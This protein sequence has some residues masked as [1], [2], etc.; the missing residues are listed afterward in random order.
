MAFAD[1]MTTNAPNTEESVSALD[2]WHQTLIG[3]A[4]S[5][6]EKA[7]DANLESI[8]STDLTVF[9]HQ[10]LDLWH[11]LYSEDKN[12]HK[13]YPHFGHMTKLQKRRAAKTLLR[14]FASNNSISSI[15]NN[16]RVSNLF[17]FERRCATSRLRSDS[18]TVEVEGLQRHKNRYEP[19]LAAGYVIISIHTIFFINLVDV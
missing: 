7:H 19:S 3:M 11:Q 9:F 13:K 10:I 1:P 16:Y 6:H 17:S 2:L 8:L 5:E 18:E 12:Q 15:Q 14:G 4:S